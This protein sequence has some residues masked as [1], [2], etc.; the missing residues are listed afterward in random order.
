MDKYFIILFSY[1]INFFRY[2]SNGPNSA[3]NV[4]N[5]SDALKLV[6]DW[7][8]KFLEPKFHEEF[9]KHMED[10][11]T[12]KTMRL[13]NRWEY[14]PQFYPDLIKL[15]VESKALIYP[16]LLPD[17]PFKSELTK[18]TKSPFLKPEEK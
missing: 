4:G 1:I 15:F 11:N 14:I 9:K 10:E 17:I 7:E 18:Y 12:I 8:N 13:K 16:Q 3:F 5:I 6:S 2:L